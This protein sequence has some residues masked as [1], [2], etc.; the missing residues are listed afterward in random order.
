MIKIRFPD[1]T[2]EEWPEGTTGMQIANKISPRL[3]KEAV[4]AKVNGTAVDLSKP[5]EA[6]CDIQIL[7]GKTPEGLDTIRH[8][9]AHLLAQAVLRLYPGVKLTIG[10]VVENGFYYD[11]DSEKKFTPEDLRVIEEQMEK[12]VKE[13]LEVFREEISKKDALK[14]FAP[15]EYKVEMI[16]EMPDEEKITLYKQGEF[17]DL[18]RGPH[19]PRT[20]LLKAWKLT[21]V[22][23]AY[24]RADAKNKQLQ[25]LYGIAF[26]NKK[27]LDEYLKMMEEAEK[28]DHRKIGKELDL[29]V[30]SDLVGSGLP[31]WTPKGT[32]LRDELDNCIWQLRKAK[33]YEKVAIPHITKQDLYETSGHW[34]KFSEDLFK[35]KTREGHIFC[36][37]PMNCPH[38]T[39]IFAG[40]SRSYRDMPQ[41]YAE[42][43][44]VYRDEHTGELSGLSRVRCI[45]Q[46]DAHVFCRKSQIKEEFMKCWDIV[47]TFY[48]L[49]GFKL[50]VRLSL[51]D[52][53]H[54]EK[55]LGTKDIWDCAE[56]NLLDIAKERGVDYKVGI[57]EAAFYGPKI[58]FMAKDSMNREWQVATIQ[59]DVNMPERFNL[60]CINENNE[61]ERVLMVHA[62]IMGSTERFLSVI[63][64]HFAGKFPLWLSPVQAV[65]MP[66]ADRHLDYSTALKKEFE[67][68]G[69]RVEVDERTESTGKKIRDAQLQKIPLMITIG[70]KEI[71]NNT[72]SVRTLDGKVKFGL[73]KALLLDK[74]KELVRS[75]AIN[76]EI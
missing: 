14:L 20:S 38:H 7:T 30:F 45:T 71:E 2:V 70:D 21:K 42:T 59:L 50:D 23:G 28:R 32:I 52:P 18:C 62:A 49:F 76:I 12:I 61:Q 29:F 69:L 57:G 41:R 66:I 75:K 54:P 64:E 39:Q 24:W 58:D 17:Y 8:S 36:M 34:A 6:D 40:R 65:I 4:A 56:N 44:M 74:I 22:A 46:D 55:Y 16:E 48:S 63:I 31:L 37:K 10:P 3:A 25:R 72:I 19:V 33:G 1:N 5:I 60:F 26:N 73:E 27:E 15:N 68:Q 53:D 43:T 67:S 35:I 13:D 9:A 51:H 47:N 11:L